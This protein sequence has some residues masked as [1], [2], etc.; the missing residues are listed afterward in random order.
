M[1]AAAVD[2]GY[3]STHLGVPATT[4]SSA[5]T[6]PTA[7]LVKAILDA[8]TAKAHEFDNLYAEK[9]KVDI[10]LESIVRSSEA[11]SDSF[12]TAAETSRT[13]VDE[14]RRKLQDEGGL[15]SR[16]KVT[17]NGRRN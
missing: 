6:E 7:D 12:K 16:P 17:T 14:L 8:V 1:A 5:V 2:T 15:L 10:E 11:R 13:E 9:L 3:L 4:L